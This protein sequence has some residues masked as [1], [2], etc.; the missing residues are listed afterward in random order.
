MTSS[1]TNIKGRREDAR[2][3]TGQGRYVSDHQLARLT[4][5]IVVRAPIAHARIA[6]IDISAAKAAP[7]VLAVITGADLVAAGIED[8][9]C[10]V[11]MPR[12]NG[13]KAFPARRPVLARD[14]VRY[15]GDAVAFVVAETIEQAR[16]AAE[17]VAVDYED[18]PSIAHTAHS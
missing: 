8:L 6:G 13:E 16:A 18:L 17:L 15:V 9:P 10:P 7:G 14:R 3:V 1:G 12:S 4:H 5:A 11:T 2:L